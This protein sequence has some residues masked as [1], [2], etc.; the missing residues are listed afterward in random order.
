M[1]LLEEM[2]LDCKIAVR[3]HPSV[4]DTL[5]GLQKQRRD[6]VAQLL[7]RRRSSSVPILLANA[8]R[9]A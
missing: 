7:S 1:K 6:S 2:G 5:R 3:Y 9:E 4:E 8:W